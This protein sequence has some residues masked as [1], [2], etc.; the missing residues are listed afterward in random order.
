MRSP[1]CQRWATVLVW[2]LPCGP[3]PVGAHCR[4][5]WENISGGGV[6]GTAF[7]IDPAEQLIA[8]L[9]LLAPKRRLY[10]RHLFDR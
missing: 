2:A 3:P 5:Q 7:W 6:Y 10:Y 9:M 4:V 1:R 8:V